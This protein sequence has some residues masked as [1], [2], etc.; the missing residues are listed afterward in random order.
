MSML[1]KKKATW[2]DV[3]NQWKELC[4]HFRQFFWSRM[5]PK[6]IK[7]ELNKR[8]LGLP[9][10][11]VLRSSKKCILEDGREG[12]WIDSIDTGRLLV[13][14]KNIEDVLYPLCR[15]GTPDEVFPKR[16]DEILN[17][18]FP[19]LEKKSAKTADRW[20][21]HLEV[22]V[23]LA[24]YC[25]EQYNE[26]GKPITKKQYETELKRQKLT[27]LSDKADRA[28]RRSMPYHML[29]RGGEKQ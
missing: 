14:I 12:I 26:C 20:E 7:W 24:V 21:K 11:P 6:E 15:V 25:M 10:L 22:A 13:W 23:K 3:R 9:P 17:R 27:L 8:E 4:N 28:F 19:M 5:L 16:K 2:S 29:E 18:I 1:D